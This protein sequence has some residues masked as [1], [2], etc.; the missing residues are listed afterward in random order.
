MKK[1]LTTV[2]KLVLSIVIS[3]V[4]LLI[5]NILRNYY[6]NQEL[7]LS[8]PSSVLEIPYQL[9]MGIS[10]GIT[11]YI[12]AK[13]HTKKSGILALAIAIYSIAAIYTAYTLI[14]FFGSRVKIEP[15]IISN[16]I[17]M[18]ALAYFALYIIILVTPVILVLRKLK[19]GKLILARY[20]LITPLVALATL[21]TYY[22][23]VALHGKSY[24]FNEKVIEMPKIKIEE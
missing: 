14:A 23:I 3:L 2:I 22:I 20:V 1:T 11:T 13:E 17:L 5:F 4:S 19:L 6:I 7:V 18:L 24:I 12:F 10:V 15:G 16:K 9:A 8:Q 21:Y